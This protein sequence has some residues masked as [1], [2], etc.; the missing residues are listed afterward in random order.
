MRKF[1]VDADFKRS[2]DMSGVIEMLSHST[3][4]EHLVEEAPRAQ[5]RRQRTREGVVGL[6]VVTPELPPAGQPC[7]VCT[8]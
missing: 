7:G 4:S 8:I 5:E 6:V 1:G 3:N 2:V